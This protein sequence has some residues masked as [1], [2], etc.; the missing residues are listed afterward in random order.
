MYVYRS[1][2][3]VFP[4]SFT[5]KVFFLAFVGTH[6]PLITL[7]VY[8]LAGRDR[9]S[10]HLD[11]VLLVLLATLLGTAL[12]LFA[13]KAILRPVYKVEQAM[14]TFEEDGNIQPLPQDMQDELGQLMQRTTRLMQRQRE[15]IET[16]QLSADTDPLTGVLNRRGFDRR[17][18]GAGQGAVLHFDLDH[19]KQI[20][21][22][23]GH[24]A[25]DLVLQQVTQVAATCLRRDDILARFGGEEFVIFLPDSTVEGAEATAER[26]RVAI[27]EK[28]RA[29][30][31]PVTASVGV[32]HGQGSL[33]A[34]IARAD[35]ATYQ[36]KS[37][38]R[39]RVTVLP[40][41]SVPQ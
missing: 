31:Q 8:L 12:T 22:T 33:A 30:G 28:V 27:A 17:I 29:N 2:A 32:S 36:S 11:V 34:L 13:L 18:S 35:Q 37:G 21:D 1:L 7:I 20:N 3:R 23:L 9:L 4:G 39:N 15:R 41:S 38:G 25:G 26:I 16:T 10:E 14:R 5:A 40:L 6:V 24:D 19:F